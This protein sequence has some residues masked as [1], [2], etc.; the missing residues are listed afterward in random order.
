M[1]ACIQHPDSGELVAAPEEIYKVTINHNL[2]ILT[3]NPV[4]P[5]DTLLAAKKQKLHDEI[6]VSDNKDQDP[7]KYTTYSTVLDR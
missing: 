3:K 5:H 7:L 1:P 4:R 6:M 2:K